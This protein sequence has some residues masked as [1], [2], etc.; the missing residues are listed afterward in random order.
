MESRSI[1]TEGW[2]SGPKGR[3][4]AGLNAFGGQRELQTGQQRGCILAH[5][6]YHRLARLAR[7]FG[8]ATNQPRADDQTV[9]DR[10]EELH[11]LRLTDAKA[12]ANRQVGLFS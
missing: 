4:I 2:V 11:M 8:N 12:D 7:G 3:Q 1:N 9:G 5:V 10:R 6:A